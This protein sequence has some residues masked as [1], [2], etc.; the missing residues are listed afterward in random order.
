MEVQTLRL[1]LERHKSDFIAARFVTPTVGESVCFEHPVTG[2]R[3]T[4]TVH[5]LENKT[6]DTSVFRDQDLEYPSHFL[7][8][9]YTLI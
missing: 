2:V 3:H 4:L 5:E 1:K 7:A 9:S 8:M 6:L